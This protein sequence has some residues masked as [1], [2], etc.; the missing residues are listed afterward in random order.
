MM[1]EEQYR[2][3]VESLFVNKNIGPDGWMHAAA[4]NSGEAGEIMEHVK[5]LW[6]AGK[7]LPRDKV[8]EEMGDQ[9]YYFTAMLNLLGVTLAEVIAGNV[10][11]LKMRYPHGYNDAAAIA[12]RDKGEHP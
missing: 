10:A 4:G 12:R 1:T 9:F 8:L 3:F 6:V 11:K 5:K 7:P 2:D